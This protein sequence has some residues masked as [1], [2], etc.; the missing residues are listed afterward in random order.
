MRFQL[1]FPIPTVRD[2]ALRSAAAFRLERRLCVMLGSHM[3]DVVR[4]EPAARFS[5]GEVRGGNDPIHEQ[6][7]LPGLRGVLYSSPC[8]GG[9][10]GDVHYLSVCGSG[11]L[12]RLCLADVAGHGETV[13]AV[14]REMHAQLLRSV[15]LV[16]QRRVLTALDERL[17]GSGLRAQTT[18]ALATYYPPSR[19]LSVSYAGHPPGWIYRVATRGWTPL[20]AEPSARAAGPRRSAARHRPRAGLH[21]ATASSWSAATACCS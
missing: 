2:S 11:L 19:R 21:A 7:E 9:R 6:V 8:G 3:A 15:D 14:G 10:G 13:E 5:C 17:V 20:V 16:D 4:L 1:D 12:S 18:A